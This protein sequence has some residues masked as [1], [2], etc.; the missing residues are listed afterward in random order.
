MDVLS[1]PAVSIACTSAAADAKT[2]DGNW[3]GGV[4]GN[5]DL[6]G[7]HFIGTA[8]IKHSKVTEALIQFVYNST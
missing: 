1:V 4:S 7:A 5:V 8:H 2:G 3:D 6:F